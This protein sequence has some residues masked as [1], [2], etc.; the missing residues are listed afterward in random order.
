ML[1]DKKEK[2]IFIDVDD[3]LADTRQAVHK[4]YTK[5]TGDLPKDIKTKSKIYAD[6]CP[7]WEDEDVAKLFENGIILYETIQP[8]PG[9]VR[10]VDELSK[11]GYD[12]RIVTLNPPSSVD[13]KHKWI[14]KHFPMLAEKVYYVDWRMKNKDVFK[15]YALIDDDMKNIRTNKSGVPILL[16]FYNIYPEEKDCIKCS[17]WE[18]VLTKI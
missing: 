1:F 8:L 9:A 5:I 10:A 4:M 12:V 13:A 15:E 11:R 16:D 2:I 7:R 14:E 6:F 3:T 18:Q 17:T